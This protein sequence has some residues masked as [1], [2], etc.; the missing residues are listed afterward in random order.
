M[1]TF[2]SLRDLVILSVRD[3]A[4]AARR[5]LSL[6]LG[7]E[8][9][10]SALLLAVV[11]NTIMYIVSDLALPPPPPEMAVFDMPAS[12]YFGLLL[13]GL[14]VTGIAVHR[15]GLLLGGQ[16]SF[17]E[18]MILLIWLQVLRALALVVV[19][20]LALTVPLLSALATLA[21]GL[22]GLYIMLNFID[23]A[24]RLDSLGRAGG[25][26]IASVLAV[27][28]GLFVLLQLAGGGATI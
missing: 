8:G 23:R 28:L 1:M 2:A 12:V 14:L 18:V 24:H 13:G 6:G 25:V 4:E 5:I 20:I 19:L 3:P 10:W 15:V 27:A 9:M 21:T 22:Y 17:A 16:G 26:L 11:L 7:R